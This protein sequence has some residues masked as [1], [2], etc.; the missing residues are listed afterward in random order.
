M[1]GL[2]KEIKTWKKSLHK[3]PSFEEGYIEELESHL[4]DLI[5]EKIAEGISQEEA[6]KFALAK[7]GKINDIGDEYFKSDTTNKISGRPSWKAPK[8]IPSLLYHNFKMAYRNIKRTAWYS[9]LNIS[10]LAVGMACAILIILWV[11]SE[12]S[13]DKFH[14]NADNLYRAYQVQEYAGAQSLITDNLP[15]PLAA[16]L[17]DQFPEIKNAIRFISINNKPIKQGDKFFNERICFTDPAFF[18]MFDFPLNR[19][20]KE[21]L[22]S[23]PFSVAITEKMAA[24]YF[25]D[26]NPIGK[27]ITI[28]GKHDFTVTGILKDFPSNS[29]LSMVE[30]LIPFSNT[31][32]IIGDKFESWRSNWPRTY[33][34][35]KEG[36]SVKSF[37]NKIEKSLFEQQTS[38]PSLHIQP[39]SQIHLYTLTGESDFVKYLYIVSVIG[40]ALLLIACINFINLSTARSRLRSKEVGLRKVSGAKRTSIALQFFGESILL[41]VFAL[42]FALTIIAILLPAINNLLGDLTGTKLVF[43]FFE[44]KNLLFTIIFVAIFTGIVSGFY[45]AVY[46]SSFQPVQILRKD[47]AGGTNKSLFRNIL[48]V[49]QFA[50]SAVLIISTLIIL[51][52]L[53]YLKTSDLGYKQNN[54]VH[55]PLS[56]NSVEKYE[57]IKNEYLKSPDILSVTATSRLPLSGGDSSSNFDWEGKDPEQQVLINTVAV[58]P[59][60]I[61]VMGMKLLEGSQI[62]ESQNSTENGP[63]MDVLLN[64]NAIE[65]MNLNTPIGK[66]LTLGNW[67]GRVIG[68]VNDFHFSSFHEEIEP[69]LIYANFESTKYMLVRLSENNT[70]NTIKHL[71]EKWRKVNPSLPFSYTFLDDSISNLYKTEK[72]ISEILKYFTGIAIFIACL[73]LLGLSSF[74]SERYTKEIGIRKVL[75]SSELSIFILLTKEF[76]K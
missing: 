75:G 35:L 45:P 51:S 55:I 13:Y 20:N 17:I 16:H 21:S 23:K 70:A 42:V 34:Q 73:G 56:G 63:P 38:K 47:F 4:R 53:E 68:V 46:L 33:I 60:Y 62:S 11:Q 28:D 8:F 76:V 25:G 64:K 41:T 10:G 6:F 40:V 29:H 74:T 32:E 27:T 59:N 49:I 58:D 66:L 7:I 26:E 30:I 52:Q 3:N 54:L 1:Y 12:L 2:D 5:E 39:L 37:E 22:I 24:K 15:G 71:E 9:I 44:N 65:R 31:N 43:N 18:E 36:A 50:C 61:N 72:R 19:G 14:K 67:K 57:I 48:V 69:I